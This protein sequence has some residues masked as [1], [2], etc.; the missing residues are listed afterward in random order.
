[1]DALGGRFIQR[2]AWSIADGESSTLLDLPA[3]K[4]RN[5]NALFCV[6]YEPIGK[7]FALEQQITR[8]LAMVR[9]AKN[10]TAMANRLP[11]EVLAKVLGFRRND[12][13]LI[14]ATHVCER[15]RST[16]LSIPLLWTEVVFGDPHRTFTYLER[17]K[18]VPI[19]VSIGESGL[20]PSA[21][22]MSWISRMNSLSINA[23][24]EQM[25]SI[26]VDLRLP[27]PF[28]QSLAFKF[29]GPPLLSDFRTV[30]PIRILPE[31]LGHQMPS[32]RNLT[33]LSVSPCPATSIPLSHLT[34]LQWT[35]PFTVVTNI[36]ALLTSAPLLEVLTLD[37]L[38]VSMSGAEL[39]K[40]VT[41]SR[42]RKLSWVNMRG[43]FSLMLFLV[44]P[45]LDDLN[46]CMAYDPT[47]S[48]PPTIFRPRR[49]HLPL[50]V[51][52]IALKYVCQD[53]D[54]SWD[55]TYRSGHLTINEGSYLYTPRPPRDHWLSPNTPISFGRVK[56]LIIEGFGDY[57]LP[58][59]IP[60]AQFE[61]LECLKLVG[62]VGRLLRIIQ[63]NGNTASG[64]LPVPSLSHLE[65]DLALG[66]STFEVLGEVLKERKEAGH[67]VKTVRIM[68]EHSGDEEA[69]ELTKF[70]DVLIRG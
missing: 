33:F 37:F 11:P 26:A 28:L 43:L 45:K 64:V 69:S 63:P 66:D 70:V 41:L 53:S 27:A 40:V 49:R 21:G 10:R 29:N 68:G 6:V 31:F 52:P 12:Q 54:R 3:K 48:D 67:G 32:L 2:Y 18:G 46:I 55:F 24:Q 4:V 51:E 9:S 65:L 25:E 13:D 5:S 44:A 57:P 61:S 17:S 38:I 35:E 39:L 59:T 58:D 19:H 62:Q 23:D 7:V 50:L 56:Q 1:M 20:D 16:L 36:F 42:L 34:N 22:D 30:N 14:S 8:I 47:H 60:I 15:W